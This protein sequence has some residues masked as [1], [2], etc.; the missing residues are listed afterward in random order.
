MTD[1]EEGGEARREG[2]ESKRYKHRGRIVEG[3]RPGKGGR[4]G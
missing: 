1:C 4:A 3:I 2:R